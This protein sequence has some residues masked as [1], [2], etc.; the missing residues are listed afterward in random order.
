VSG[1]LRAAAAGAT[2]A[3]IWA[4]EEPL[5]QQL[6]RCDYSDVALLGKAVTR[7][8]RWRAA[9]LAIH[10]LNGALFGLAFHH[11][12]RILTV[13]PKKLALGMA[14]AEHIGLFPLCYFVDRYHPARGEPGIP[15]LL[16]NPRAFAQATWRHML[17]GAV[18][19]WLG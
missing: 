16:P 13:D 11:A 18:L 2:A 1:R 17:F 15:P 9:G 3:T 8:P 14:L 19:G 10:A 12:R 6:L 4:L 7:G 5:D